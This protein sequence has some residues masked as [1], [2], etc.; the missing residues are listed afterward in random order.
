MEGEIQGV[1]GGIG[2]GEGKALVGKELAAEGEF[3]FA[4]EN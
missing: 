2:M 4:I 1:G 3:M